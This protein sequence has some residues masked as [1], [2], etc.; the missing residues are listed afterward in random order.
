MLLQ[1]YSSNPKAIEKTRQTKETVQL[2]TGA[3]EMMS[4]IVLSPDCR[5]EL[6]ADMKRAIMDCRSA[7]SYAADP[8]GTIPRHSSVDVF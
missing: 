3:D 7:F 1:E 6:M 8:V 2:N 5:V 4:P